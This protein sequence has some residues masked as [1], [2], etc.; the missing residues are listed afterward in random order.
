[1]IQAK[2]IPPYYIRPLN[3]GVVIYSIPKCKLCEN[4]L[5]IISHHSPVKVCCEKY[6]K[7]DREG[8]LKFMSENTGI[9]YKIEGKITFPIIFFG[10]RYIGGYSE[11]MTEL[12]KE[13]F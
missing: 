2:L 3:I 13:F 10:K 4:A 1:M 5:N 6:L 12:N 9:D 8:F 11:L 7:E